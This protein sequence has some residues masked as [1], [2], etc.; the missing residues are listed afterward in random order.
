MAKLNFLSWDTTAN[1]NTDVGNININE[2]CA[3]SGINNAIREMMAQLRADIDGEM[4]YATKAVNYTAV[5]NDN[6]GVI[7]CTAAL[8]LTLTAVATLGANW[9]LWVYANGGDVT[10]DPNAAELINGA[11]TLVIPNGSSALVIS[12]GSAFR[13]IVTRGAPPY[14]VKTGAYTAVSADNGG[15]I[16]FTTAATLSLTAAATLGSGWRVKII[17]YGV[18]VTIDPNAS[19]QINGA[20]TFILKSG[21]TADIVCDGSAFWADVHGDT[22]SGPQGQGYFSGLALTT[23]ADAANDVTIAAGA[24]AADTSPYYLMQLASALTKQIDASWAVGN[25]AGGL[26][27]GAVGNNTYYKWLIQRSDTG[28]TDALLSLSSTAPTM[29]TNYDRKRLVG[30]LGRASATN[31]A[32]VSYL[33]GMARSGSITLSST[34]VDIPIG[35]APAGK[36]LDK[37]T[38]RVT[39]V[40]LSAVQAIM[41]QIMVAGA[42]VTSGYVGST[43]GGAGSTATADYTSFIGLI[44]IAT[45]STFRAITLV[46]ARHGVGSNTWS[47]AITGQYGSPGYISGS[48]Y[49]TLA[50]EPTGLR[51]STGTAVPTFTNGTASL[52]LEYI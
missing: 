23:A 30:F 38:L 15:V 43:S 33:P 16:R 20:A 26:D 27:T 3:P 6:N 44:H 34:A 49:V 22:L 42:A 1:N 32:P 36:E 11:A 5:A 35:A 28:V 45:V 21:Q 7:E 9:H 50:G 40:T 25:N 10:I 47:W 2:G 39:N 41:A 12:T 48:G 24:A 51:V 4:V 19:E 46:M 17:A 13:A 31:G 18:D 52:M 37:I 14:S 8:T 29:P